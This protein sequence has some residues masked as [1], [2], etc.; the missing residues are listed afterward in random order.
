MLFCNI[1]DMSNTLDAAK[2][3]YSC[4]LRQGKDFHGFAAAD[5]GIASGSNNSK[6]GATQV[7]YFRQV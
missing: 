3:Q 7:S 5:K 4:N 1:F 2:A 6:V